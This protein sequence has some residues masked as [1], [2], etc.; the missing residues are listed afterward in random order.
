MAA[1]VGAIESQFYETNADLVKDA[2]LLEMLGLL[3]RFVE[4]K[5]ARMA[6]ARR[7]G[8]YRE[9]YSLSEGIETAVHRKDACDQGLFLLSGFAQKVPL[10]RH[11]LCKSRFC[12]K[13]RFY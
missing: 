10:N 9:Q 7:K 4:G 8:G 13:S 12:T 11:I 6:L 3:W 2:P 1:K 5:P